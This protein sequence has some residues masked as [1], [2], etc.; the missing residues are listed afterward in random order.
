MNTSFNP[1]V[2]YIAKSTYIIADKDIIANDCRLIYIISGSGS[3]ESGGKTYALSSG[4]LLYYPCGTP[5]KFTV[6]PED[7][8]LFY[9]VNFDFS[10][11]YLNVLPMGPEDYSG[12]PPSN[13]LYTQ[14]ETEC[15][16]FENIIY[17]P[18][19]IW[20]EDA[21]KRICEEGIIKN[22]GYRAV[23]SSIMKIILIN[24]F[25]SVQG[26]QNHSLCKKVKDILSQNINL[27][28]KEIAKMLNYHPFYLNDIFKK[29]EGI[30]VHQYVLKQKLA[31]AY[32][33]ITSTQMT[34]DEIALI[35]GFSSQSHL[36]YA[37]KK[38]FGITPT[39]IRKLL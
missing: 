39:G 22:E 12:K 7:K 21:L 9:T 35:C 30:T 18:A 2:R 37:F 33:L 4:K 1:F 13:I 24:I 31:K 6:N 20:C 8:L 16:M 34:I 27:S 28:N 17:L 3:L 5:Y 23:Q 14:P 10:H 38:S 11:R 15:E 19:A 32:E 36:S 29:E 25:R 26:A